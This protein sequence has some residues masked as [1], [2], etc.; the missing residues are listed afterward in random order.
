VA[1]K[2]VIHERMGDPAGYSIAYDEER[3]Y[4]VV[5][6]VDEA[7][8]GRFESRAQAIAAAEADRAQPSR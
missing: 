8:I 5:R 1:R 6:V 3:W 4:L 2:V 7:S